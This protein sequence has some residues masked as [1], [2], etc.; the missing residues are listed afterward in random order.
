MRFLRD[1]EGGASRDVLL[2]FLFSAGSG[3]GGCADK[4][5]MGRLNGQARGVLKGRAVAA[6]MYARWQ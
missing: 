3:R 4:E 6:L 5:W 2:F 1:M